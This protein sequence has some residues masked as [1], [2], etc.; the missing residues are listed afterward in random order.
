MAARVTF[1]TYPPDGNRNYDNRVPVFPTTPS[2]LWNHQLWELPNDVPIAPKQVRWS[3]PQVRFPSKSMYS[4]DSDSVHNK[5]YIKSNPVRRFLDPEQQKQVRLREEE[6]YSELDY[7]NES[8]NRDQQLSQLYKR[9]GYVRARLPEYTS[10]VR[11]PMDWDDIQADRYE[12]K[13]AYL[14]RVPEDPAE[15][16][17]RR[18]DYLSKVPLPVD[19]DE[20]PIPVDA[21]GTFLSPK[22]ELRQQWWNF[23]EKFHPRHDTPTPTLMKAETK[24]VDETYAKDGKKMLALKTQNLAASGPYTRKDKHGFPVTTVQGFQPNPQGN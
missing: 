14:S 1:G 19:L 4:K 17:A 21:S 22:E 11:V 3:T 10:R 8:R 16:R 20:I 6:A 12:R 9:P 2:Q 7:E 5:A 24:W 23:Q 13:L 15:I 18:L